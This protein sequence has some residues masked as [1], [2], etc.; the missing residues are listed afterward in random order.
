MLPV[1]LD[2]E[3]SNRQI[4]STPE[5]DPLTIG[6]YHVHTRF[7]LDS[8]ALM[9]DQCEAAIAAGIGEIAFTEHVD[10]DSCDLES[11]KQYDYAAYGDEIE[12]C[13]QLFGDRLQILRAAE[14]DWNHSIASKV[15]DFLSR[16]AFDFII[17][18]VHN[19]DHR[20]VGFDTVESFGGPRAMYESYFDEL[21]GLVRTGFPC[22]V[23]HCDLP[24]RYHEIAPLDVDRSHFEGR[25]REL[26]REAARNGVGF[27]LNTSG[28][29]RGNGVTYPEPAIIK[30][31]IEEGGQVITIG[32]DSH[33][34]EHTGD[35]IRETEQ[36]LLDLGIDSRT[37]FVR[38]TP[39]RVALEGVVEHV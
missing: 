25:Y 2:V 12:R 17:G 35:S 18:S 16:T 21:L 5:E 10:H 3:R 7:S 20:Y 23:G 32:S 39:Q 36:A 6:D 37:S 13:R 9:T 11:M 15:N 30:W 34:P 28:I 38:G 27:E 22:V 29:R 4:I 26:F 1:I 33:R 24:R 14:V 8:Q 19:L 31:F